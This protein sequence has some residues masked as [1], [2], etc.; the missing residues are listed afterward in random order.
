MVAETKQNKL[1]R[2]GKAAAAGRRRY[3]N[4]ALSLGAVGVALA[5]SIAVMAADA[6]PV[7]LSVAPPAPGEKTIL[8][9]DGLE[10]GR[11]SLVMNKSTVLVT[12]APYKRVSV[13]SP[14]IADV[15]PIGPNNVLVTAKKTGTTQL[16]LWDDIDRSQVV[17]VA[18]G[19]DIEAL[20]KQLKEMFPGSKIDA[21]LTGGQLVLRGSV[22]NLIVADQAAQLAAPFAPKVLNFLEVSGG[23]QVMLQVRFAEVS[24]SATNQL[25]VNFGFT[26]GGAFAGSN[27]GQVSPL[28][29]ADG[30]A[31]GVPGPSA[32]VT[33]FGRGLLGQSAFNYYITALRQNNLLRVL[34][35]PNLVA[36]SGQEAS[37]L[38]GGEF[39][40]PVT[41][42]GGGQGGTAITIE[43]RS[44]GVK[45]NFTPLVLGDGRIRLKVAPEVSDLD[46]TTAVRFG[47]FVIP[48]V[49]QRKLS[50]VVEL[51]EGQ[52][53]ALAGLLNNN[54]ST[55]KDVTPVL[56]DL[57]VVGALFRS[58]RYQ[59]KETELVVIVTPRIVEALNP[60]QVPVL[61]GEKWRDPSE[62]DL[63]WNRDLG[64]VAGDPRRAPTAP[65]A[66][67]KAPLFRGQYGYTPVKSEE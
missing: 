60:A 45:L 24:R 46:F 49:T 19:V 39:P 29:V 15:N 48:G 33:L 47:G 41:Q 17:D 38:A 1:A 51:G 4:A 26:D 6:R 63:F 55:T 8:V 32:A 40:I 21:T 59:R 57:P 31:L 34:A 23:Q 13:G 3:R 11:L 58:V 62:A 7:A 65:R 50:T 25:G 54:V 44:Y 18:V 52:T 10:G 16:I 37:F 43:Y 14:E 20:K 28:G 56:G 27:I 67:G 61:P 36:I 42:G 66:D 12:R 2:A 35:E 5:V 22:P 53:L 30:P 64:G 9:T